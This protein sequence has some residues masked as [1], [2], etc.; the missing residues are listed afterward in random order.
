M[1]TFLGLALQ[2]AW[3]TRRN[4]L[5]KDTWWSHIVW[6]F[7]RAYQSELMQPEPDTIIL[8]TSLPVSPDGKSRQSYLQITAL[9][10]V[11]NLLSEQFVMKTENIYL[12]RLFCMGSSLIF[13]PVW[14]GKIPVSSGTRIAKLCKSFTRDW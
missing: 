4:L 3:T 1:D 13:K 9:H 14:P 7:C 12:I 2:L 5:P 8:N 10:S 6:A 11:M